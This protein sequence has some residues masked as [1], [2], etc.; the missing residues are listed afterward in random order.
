MKE[1]PRA[2]SISFLMWLILMT[3]CLEAQYIATMNGRQPAHSNNERR[4]SANAL[5]PESREASAQE[6][7]FVAQK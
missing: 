4:R 2:I 7:K 3:G 5:R 6:E 1:I